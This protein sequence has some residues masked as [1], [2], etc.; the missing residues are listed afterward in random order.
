MPLVS[1]G[2][3]HLGQAGRNKVQENSEPLETSNP[4]SAACVRKRRRF[5][6]AHRNFSVNFPCGKLVLR[7]SLHRSCGNKQEPTVPQFLIELYASTMIVAAAVNLI[8]STTT[9]EV[10]S[11][12]CC[13]FTITFT[14]G[15][16]R[17]GTPVSGHTLL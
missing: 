9:C 14:C 8:L 10:R 1:G 5:P 12:T 6:V 17:E 11:V 7:T 3:G 16:S 2:Q 15:G 13:Q 4:P